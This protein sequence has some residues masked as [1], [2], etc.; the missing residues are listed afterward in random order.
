MPFASNVIDSSKLT[1][2]TGLAKFRS[3]ILLVLSAKVMARSLPMT[4]WHACIKASA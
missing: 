3:R 1:I 4:Y 2:I